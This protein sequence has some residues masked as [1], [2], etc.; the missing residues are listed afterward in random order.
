MDSGKLSNNFLSRVKVPAD[1]DVLFEYVADV[2][3]FVKDA[4]GRFVRANQAFVELVGAKS[5]R[6]V[7][8]L[9]DS[10]FFPPELADAYAR[11]DA[12]VLDTG[13]SVIDKPEPVRNPDGSI[14]W[15]CTTK[16]PLLDRSGAVIGIAGI[17]RDVKRM[18][19]NNARFTSW[20]PVVEAMLNDYASP[21]STT[22]LAQM[23]D[24]S[25]S[26]F[27]RQFRKRFHTTPR[28]YLMR[29]RLSAACHFLVRTDLSL[30]EIALR[31][32]F[33]DQSHFSNQFVR[34]HG[35]APS[36]YRAR[37]HEQPAGEATSSDG[38]A[39]T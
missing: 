30:A 22:S 21:L 18:S 7:I 16:L 35:M 5:E 31:T 38:D 3:Y 39:A 28:A 11:D 23:L 37:H 1:F 33:Y 32:G 20:A 14:D 9:R 8:G 13:Q 15:F 19:S 4:D 26:Q 17:T 24:I 6:D 36:K 2:Y 12:A 29:V 34:A 25:V 10:D 27:N